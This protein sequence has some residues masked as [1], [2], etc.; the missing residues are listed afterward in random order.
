MRFLSIF[1]L[2][3]VTAAS[4]RTAIAVDVIFQPLASITNDRNED[5]QNLGILLV[6]GQVVGLRFDTV[7]G[8][9]PHQSYFSLHEMDRGAVLDGDAKHKAIVMQGHIDSTAGNADLDVTYLSNGLLG[10]H[11]DCRAGLVR[12]EAG[13]WHI[14]NTYD[15]KRVEHLFV[16]TRKLGILTIEGICPSGN[17]PD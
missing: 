2:L 16:R 7:N 11:K 9:H 6:A 3:S 5:V 10:K 17:R 1:V 15:H 8:R 12:D 4:V 14:V 13:R